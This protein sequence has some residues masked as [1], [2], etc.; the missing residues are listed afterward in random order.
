MRLRLYVDGFNL[1]HRLLKGRVGCKWLDLVQLAHR[2]FPSDELDEVHYFTAR[3]KAL[4][5]P[6][7]PQRQQVYLRALDTQSNVR[8]HF[9]YFQIEKKWRRLVTPAPGRKKSAEVFLPEEKGSDVN[10]AAHLVSD[11][12]ERRYKKAAVLSN[13]A[14]LA[15]PIRI[16]TSRLGI[17]VTVLHP[18]R[19]PATVLRKAMPTELK[20][21]S[22]S[23]VRQCQLPSTLEDP[24]GTI[25][26]PNSW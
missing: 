3:I 11:G 16:V 5:D 1:Y 4:G 13:D 7:A 2:L 6:Q 12:Y 9:G 18:P 24:D 20:R 25:Q 14:D 22:L 10:L 23:S 17:P 21:L 26:K 15:E 8:V 19:Y